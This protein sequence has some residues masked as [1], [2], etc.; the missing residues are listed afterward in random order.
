MEVDLI[1]IVFISKIYFTSKKA[2]KEEI[3]NEIYCRRDRLQFNKNKLK[4]F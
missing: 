4:Q 1:Q 2:T 3:K